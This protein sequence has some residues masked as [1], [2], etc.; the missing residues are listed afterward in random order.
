ASA[1]LTLAEWGLVMSRPDVG[2]IVVYLHVA[3]LGPVLASGFWSMVSERFDPRSAKREIGRIAGV[4]TLGGL[5]GGLLAER[6]TAWVGVAGT[7][8]ALAL[9]HA[10]CAWS[11]T[12]L[13]SVAGAGARPKTEETLALREVGR[14][15]RS[16]PYLRNLALLVL[17]S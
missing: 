8:P 7:L 3:A 6:L 11:T 2:A 1:L 13:P 17:T 15:L 14:R 4:G 16:T 10:W 9:A 12:R 5:V